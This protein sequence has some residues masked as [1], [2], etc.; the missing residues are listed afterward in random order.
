MKKV[1]LSIVLA[2]TAIAAPAFAQTAVPSSQLYTWAAAPTGTAGQLGNYL[3]LN[4]LTGRPNNYAMD[5]T[6]TGTAP[7][8][9]TFR[10]EASSDLVAWYGVD[11]V[12]PATVSCTANLM[13]WLT[14][15]PARYL[16]INLTYTQGDATTKVVFHYTGGTQ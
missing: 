3:I 2:F 16:R 9:C 14:A 5:V 1:L 11:A 8:T 7:A 12:S 13:E 4:G 6:V 10:T 15:K